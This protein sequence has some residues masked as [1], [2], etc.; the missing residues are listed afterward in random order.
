MLDS[1]QKT[2]EANAAG[3]NSLFIFTVYV[4][5]VPFYHFK[6]DFVVLHMAVTEFFGTHF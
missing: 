6:L 4:K 2:C 5:F 1:C 3:E